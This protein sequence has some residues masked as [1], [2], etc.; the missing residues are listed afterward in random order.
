M[1][2][3]GRP[4]T[5]AGPCFRKYFA[6]ARIVATT[7]ASAAKVF[8]GETIAGFAEPVRG[9]SDCPSRRVGERKGSGEKRGWGSRLGEDVAADGVAADGVASGPETPFDSVA[10]EKSGVPP[11]PDDAEKRSAIGYGLAAPLPLETSRR[12]SS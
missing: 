4:A 11:A 3:S 2:S 10:A 12:R 7:K 5:E 1:A 9:S 8:Q 6:M